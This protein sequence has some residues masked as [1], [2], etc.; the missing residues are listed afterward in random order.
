[1]A[2]AQPLPSDL[3]SQIS[4]GLRQGVR[5]GWSGY[6]WI[7][8]IVVPVS[9]GVTLLQWT[10]WLHYANFLLNPLMGLLHLPGEAA[11]PI[12]S[13]MVINI[14]AG[15]A[16]MTVLK[17]SIPQMTLMAIFMLMAHN[18]IV[19]STIQHKSGLHAVKAL[20][21]RIGLAVITVFVVSRFFGDTAQSIDAASA[22]TVQPP[23]LETLQGWAIDTLKLLL[24]IFVLIMVIVTTMEVCRVT[25]WV[26]YAFR[27]CQPLMKAMGLPPETTMLWV[28]AEVFGLMYG[29]A[30]IVDE[31]KQ[32]N[33]GKTDLEYLHM[34]VAVNHSVIEDTALFMALGLNIFWLL[35]PK[36]LVAM[37]SVHAVRSY[38]Y[39]RSRTKP[40][41]SPQA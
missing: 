5:K 31:A 40:F 19:E 21:W 16:S 1:M 36:V 7:V 37:A 14:Y 10:G 2:K 29:A 41:V 33:M 38:R 34:S 4:L 9:L 39:L 22:G 27:F 8:K 30:V 25:R 26:E 13:G 11:L 23:L 3:K 6:L 24:K 28:T 15:I 18:L 35:V 12:L 17:F 20:L 32:R